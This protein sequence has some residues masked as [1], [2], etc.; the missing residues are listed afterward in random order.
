MKTKFIILILA[1]IT[2]S[3]CCKKADQQS[4]KQEESIGGPKQIKIPK[5]T[6]AEMKTNFGATKKLLNDAGI[7][8][9][10]SFQ[11]NLTAL[12][13]MLWI[14][15]ETGDE[16]LFDE[17]RIYFIQYLKK[18]NLNY[19]DL[20]PFDNALYMVYSK[21]KNGVD[22]PNYYAV[23]SLNKK[24]EIKP[25]D[26]KKMK[27][28]YQK[29]IKP[30]INQRVKDSTK[31][32]TDYVKI[33]RE[34]LYN[35]YGKIKLY[36]TMNANTVKKVGFMNICLSEALDYKKDKDFNN[37]RELQ[38]LDQKKYMPGQLTV[39]FDVDD[40]S[41][42]TIDNLSSYDMNSLCPQQCP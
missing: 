25:E 15:N 37:I 23:F 40:S 35:H 39:I 10:D 2:L 38:L 42:L 33:P 4:P 29:N 34:E 14:E 1:L 13:N 30:I 26:F 20:D 16:P 22:I 7:K 32:N 8:T 21:T 3:G 41:S 27:E 19:K 12:E 11:L 31:I 17:I 36:D 24:V 5:A 18:D 28:N 6:A 9:F